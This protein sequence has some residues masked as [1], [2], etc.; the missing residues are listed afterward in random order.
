MR[1]RPLICPFDKLLDYLPDNVSS[2]DIGCGTGYL[3]T[4]IALEKHPTAL[5][6]TEVTQQLIGFAHDQIRKVTTAPLRLY[7]YDGKLP[8][9]MSQYDF[10]WMID[11]LH[12][13]PADKQVSSIESIVARMRP[14]AVLV[15]KDIDGGKMLCVANKIHDLLSS[16]EIGSELPRNLTGSILKQSGLQIVETGYK[17][18]W[19]YPHYWYVCRK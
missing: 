17:R 14:G 4:R 10:V 15:L 7:L 1:A 18:M 12:H 6:G 8:E 16:G 13:I 3:L 11:V 2:F 9:E 5:G 19:W